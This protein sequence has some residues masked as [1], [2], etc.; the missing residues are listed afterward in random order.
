MVPRDIPITIAIGLLRQKAKVH[1]YE[2]A[3]ACTEIGAGM[4]FGPNSRRAMALIDERIHG[5]GYER[6]ATGNGWSEKE[7]TYFE[8]RGWGKI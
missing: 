1:I 6:R 5:E 3:H 2:A 7:R 8:F 4:A